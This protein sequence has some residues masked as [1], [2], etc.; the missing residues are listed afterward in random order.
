MLEE[1]WW[2]HQDSNLGQT[3]YESLADNQP[4]LTTTACVTCSNVS[5]RLLYCHLL[6]SVLI[7]CAAVVQIWSK[8]K[9]PNQNLHDV[10]G[11][12]EILYIARRRHGFN[13]Q[14]SPVEYEK[15]YKM[16]LES[17]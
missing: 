13:N 11:Y 17:V 10:F 5:S 6:S 3:D 2:A 8:H 4:L 16:R 15:Q 1:D 9:H 14:L 7:R 12:L